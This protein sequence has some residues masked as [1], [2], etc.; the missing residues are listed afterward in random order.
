MVLLRVFLGFGLFFGEKIFA[1]ESASKNLAPLLLNV[2]I[3]K[4]SQDFGPKT[5]TSLVTAPKSPLSPLSPI[6]SKFSSGGSFEISDD[7]KKALKA[8]EDVIKNKDLQQSTKESQFASEPASKP[9]NEQEKKVAA[10]NTIKRNFKKSKSRER[11]KADM[12]AK[13]QSTW[14]RDEPMSGSYKD[15]LDPINQQQKPSKGLERNLAR[16]KKFDDLMK[17]DPEK[18]KSASKIQ[19]A[20]RRKKALEQPSKSVSKQG[21]TRGV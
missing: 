13:A 6:K 20:F 14:L 2:E 16:E 17:S 11:A 12:T 5:P 10:A 8:Q 3:D 4:A 18:Q 7:D 9:S 21:R 15:Y 19:K 1:Q